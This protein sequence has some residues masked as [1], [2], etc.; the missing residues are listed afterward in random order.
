MQTC[1]SCFHDKQ[2]SCSLP[3]DT[4]FLLLQLRLNGVLCRQLFHSV[5]GNADARSAG[6][7]CIGISAQAID[8]TVQTNRY[9]V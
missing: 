7:T 9:A 4:R 8:F 3:A 6:I 2:G 1:Q 5:E